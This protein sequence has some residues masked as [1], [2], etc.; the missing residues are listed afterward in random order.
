MI[1]QVNCV[2]VCVH[3]R[4]RLRVRT[5]A[6]GSAA[7]CLS[8]TRRDTSAADLMVPWMK[9]TAM[10]LARVPRFCSSDGEAGRRLACSPTQGRTEGEHTLEAGNHCRAWRQALYRSA[11]RVAAAGLL[12]TFLKAAA[13]PARAAAYI[14]L[15][16]PRM[17]LCVRL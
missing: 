2:C 9:G 15:N 13:L 17:A 3:A 4:V 11:C 7:D 8:A 5:W 14:R 10:R 12:P 6:S 1:S 16:A